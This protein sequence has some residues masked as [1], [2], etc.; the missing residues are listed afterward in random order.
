M[1]GAPCGPGRDPA[2]CPPGP[3]AAG[4][5]SQSVRTTETAGPCGYDADGKARGRGRNVA[6][7]VG[8]APVAVQV[9]TVD[10]QDRDDAPDV[11]P[12]TPGKVPAAGR[13]WADSGHGGERLEVVRRRKKAKT[14]RIDVRRMVRALRA[15]DGGDRDAMSPAPI[16]TVAEEEGRRLVCSANQH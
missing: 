8:G 3:T 16:P 13:V 10:V 6:A 5:G 9:R 11:I 4:T 7:G 1:P 15:W 12:G 2:G 14:D